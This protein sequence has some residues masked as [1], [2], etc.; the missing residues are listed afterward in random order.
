MAAAVAAPRRLCQLGPGKA[1]PVLHLLNLLFILLFILR[2]FTAQLPPAHSGSRSRGGLEAL[3]PHQLTPG[4]AT[5]GRRELRASGQS[6]ASLAPLSHLSR[7]S[8]APLSRGSSWLGLLSIPV[9]RTSL[10]PFGPCWTLDGAFRSPDLYIELSSTD[11]ARTHQLRADSPPRATHKECFSTPLADA[12]PS[13]SPRPPRRRLISRALS[14][15]L[16]LS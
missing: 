9:A 8:L 13:L 12:L 4:S 15:S 16:P 14:L 1:H 2:F 10:A 7:T 11:I 6:L 3:R 5:P